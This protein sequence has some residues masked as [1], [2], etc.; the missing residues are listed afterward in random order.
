MIGRNNCHCAVER[1]GHLNRK[2]KRSAGCGECDMTRR[3]EINWQVIARSLLP[4]RW[5]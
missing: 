1:H 2:G 5:C 4:P 3:E